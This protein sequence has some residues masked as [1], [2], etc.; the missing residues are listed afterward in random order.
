LQQITISFLLPGDFMPVLTSTEEQSIRPDFVGELALKGRRLNV[1][2]IDDDP[3][4]HAITKA[5]LDPRFYEFHGFESLPD[6]GN[7]SLLGKYD[8][9][10]L[11]YYLPAVNGLEIAQY[12]DAFFRDMP[13]IL[14]SGGKPGEEEGATIW[15]SCIQKYVNKAHGPKALADA[16]RDVSNSWALAR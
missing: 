9:A 2:L 10:I 13:V 16:I 1:L 15:P 6:M 14:V 4:F 11:D 12:V 8:I 7:F 5:I 3:Y